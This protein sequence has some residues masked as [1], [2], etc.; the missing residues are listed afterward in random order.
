MLVDGVVVCDC[1]E[2]VV[3]QSDFTI[4]SI[5]LT[6]QACMLRARRASNY[7]AMSM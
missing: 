3:F 1:A 6:E 2:S 4:R 5:M 7:V